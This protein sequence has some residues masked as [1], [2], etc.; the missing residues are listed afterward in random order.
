MGERT[1][2]IPCAQGSLSSGAA[3]GDRPKVI[4]IVGYKKVGKTTLIERLIPELSSRGY[5]VGTVKHHHSDFPVEVDAQGTDSSRH[6][7]AGASGVA[8]VTPT[9]V[10][11]FRDTPGGASLEE[12]AAAL[13]GTDIV[14]AEGF[15]QAPG[16][17]IE[18]LSA[19]NAQRRC[20]GDPQLLA[21]V[22]PATGDATIASFE[23]DAVKSLADFIEREVLG[24]PG[25]PGVTKDSKFEIPSVSQLPV[26]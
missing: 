17:K 12:V 16:L 1:L 11:L 22:G 7:R 26:G 10:A 6:R 14:L 3:S 23:P 21:T 4:L 13:H 25:L 20:A 9:D 15:H 8:L 2:C 19:P 24:K 5:R 18:V